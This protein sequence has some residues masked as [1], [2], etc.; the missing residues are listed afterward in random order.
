MVRCSSGLQVVIRTSWTN[1]NPGRRFYGCPTFLLESVNEMRSCIE[2]L[3]RLTE[4]LVAYKMREKLKSLQKDDLIKVHNY[5]EKPIRIKPGLAGIV[6]VAKL[7]KIADT[8]EGGEESVM[9]TQEYIRKVI[10]DVGKDEDFRRGSWLSA[11]KYV[12]VDGGIVS[13]CF[14]DIKKFLKN[15]K[16]HKVVTIIK[17][18]TLN[19]LG[20]LT[21]TLKDLSGTISSTIHYK[22]L[23]EER[24]G[25]AITKLGVPSTLDFF[26]KGLLHEKFYNSLG[27]APNR[28]SVVWAR[29]RVV[30]YSLE[31]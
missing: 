6:Q 25:K 22:L 26:N 28:R 27:S 17:S 29:L 10:Q 3:E 31:E 23:M 4:N 20:D 5:G 11:V 14:G 24:F 21:V 30:Y 2:E 16:L 19:A 13:G 9:S 1:R 12:N 7:R 18:Y 8:Q 15:G